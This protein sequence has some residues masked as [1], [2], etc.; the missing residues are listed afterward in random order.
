MPS[1]LEE[2]CALFVL[3]RFENSFAATRDLIR[4]T[5]GEIEQLAFLCRNRVL[6]KEHV[7]QMLEFREKVLLA[8]DKLVRSYEENRK[9]DSEESPL[10]LPAATCRDSSCPVQPGQDTPSHD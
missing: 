8:Y 5:P 9:G 4:V 3:A 1:P 2:A 6:V 10:H 7:E